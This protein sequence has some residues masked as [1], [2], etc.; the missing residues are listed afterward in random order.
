MTMS[1][2][3]PQQKDKELPFCLYFDLASYNVMATSL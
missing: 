2:T 3:S 1:S